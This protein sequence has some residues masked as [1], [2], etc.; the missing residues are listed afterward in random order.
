LHVVER[1]LDIPTPDGA[2][3]VIIKHPDG[4]GPFP[5][6][7]L[8]HDGPG[9]RE[10]THHS[11][12]GLAGA[13]FFVATPDRYH[14]FGRFVSVKPED[15]IAS[16]PNSE[17]M[18]S[19][20]SMVMATTDDLVRADVDALLSHLQEQITGSLSSAPTIMNSPRFTRTREP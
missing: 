16:G 7:L 17:L 10:A 20:F 4:D 13:G 18:R 1:I 15:L 3:A 12:R 5:V 14:R 2:V 8:F 11:A 19:F 6:V 9:L